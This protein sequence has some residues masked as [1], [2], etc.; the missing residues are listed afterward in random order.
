MIQTVSPSSTS[1]NSAA[2][3]PVVV[4]SVNIT[5]E[6]GSTLQEM[7]QVC[8]R[9][10]TWKS[11]A[12]PILKLEN[13]H[14]LGRHLN[15]WDTL[16]LLISPQSGVMAGTIT[17]SPLKSHQF[18]NF[19]NLSNSLMA[20]E[21]V[22]MPPMAPSQT[23]WMSDVHGATTMGLTRHPWDHTCALFNPSRLTTPNIAKP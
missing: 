20:Q 23:V 13:F 16:W 5:A 2:W 9:L 21:H 12:N 11:S 4:I 15:A 1:A 14:P 8:I 19:H 17:L 22:C 3:K 7:G 10:P 6:T 18:T